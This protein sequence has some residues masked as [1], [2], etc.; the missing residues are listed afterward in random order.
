MAERPAAM[1]RRGFLVAA[2]AGL[3]ASAFGLRRTIGDAVP[4]VFVPGTDPPIELGTLPDG[5]PA[6]PHA[7]EATLAKD[8]AGNPVAPRFHRLAMFDLPERPGGEDVRRFEAAL[9]AMERRFE[10]GPQG[11]LFVVGWGPAYFGSHVPGVDPVPDPEPLSVFEDP[12]LDRQPVCVHLAADDEARLADVEE[13]LVA[14]RGPLQDDIPSI[15][16]SLVH[17]ETRT[18]FSGEGLPAARQDVG[19][20]PS[21]R[22]VAA[23]APLFMGYKSGFRRNQATEDDVTIRSGPL[24]GG[25][26]M[27]VSRIRLRLDSWY[28]LLDDDQRAARMFAPQLDDRAVRSLRDEA[29]TNADSIDSTA[30][31]VGVIGHLQ[32]AAG[33]RRKGRPVILRRDFN[34]TDGE[35]AGLHFVSLQ[36]TIEDFVE[37]R[38][39]MN[40]ARAASQHPGIDGEVNNGIN[41]FMIVTN[42][43]NFVV[44]PRGQRSFPLLPGRERWLGT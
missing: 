6:R 1:H 2:A 37:T 22:P 21:S 24:A 9:R 39:A 28:G 23:D 3:A 12:V 14:G 29:P 26:T 27:H 41:E 25:C 43:A 20:I 34:S 5:R 38:R 42:R 7:W 36:A 15:G 30:R 19:G 10:H 11:L 33:A 16:D 4:E 35:Q 40:A 13:A 44:P 18:G 31:D 8:A 17:L 32:A